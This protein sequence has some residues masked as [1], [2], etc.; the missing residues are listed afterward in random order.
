MQWVNDERHAARK[1]RGINCRV[2]E[3]GNVRVGDAVEVVRD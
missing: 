2:L 1:L 3:A